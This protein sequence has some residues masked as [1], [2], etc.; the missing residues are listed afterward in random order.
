MANCATNERVFAS[1]SLRAVRKLVSAHFTATL[2]RLLI[3]LLTKESQIRFAR[4]TKNGAQRNKARV[5]RKLFDLMHAR[6][7]IEQ[8]RQLRCEASFAAHKLRKIARF[9]KSR[10][11]SNFLAP[12]SKTLKLSRI[13]FGSSRVLCSL[14]QLKPLARRDFR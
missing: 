8:K 5:R 2:R 6:F 1:H 3:A 9:L 11:E 10:E 7:R 12:I 13:V 14:R 4:K